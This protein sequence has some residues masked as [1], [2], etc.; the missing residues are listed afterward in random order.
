MKL[1]TLA[2]LAFLLVGCA[3]TPALTSSTD[4]SSAK[5]FV[6]NP[7]RAMVYIY[8]DF[9][10]IHTHNIPV[11]VGTQIVAQLGGGTF[12]LAD[13]APGRYTFTSVGGANNPPLTLDVQ[14]GRVYFLRMNQL[15]GYGY[16]GGAEYIPVNESEG[17]KAVLKRR[18]V[19][20][21]TK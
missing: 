13:L 9:A 17:K 6:A 12:L 14:A 20:V 3:S 11:V 10:P 19:P 8:A 4:E 7:K 15:Y 16:L 5:G 21:V 18:R 1:Q 2:I